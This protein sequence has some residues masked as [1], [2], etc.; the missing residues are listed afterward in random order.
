MAEPLYDYNLTC[1]LNLILIS[2]VTGLL[3]E[4]S[5]RYVEPLGKKGEAF[6]EERM[7]RKHE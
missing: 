4:L 2:A 6:I 7:F 1:F 5:V 3:S